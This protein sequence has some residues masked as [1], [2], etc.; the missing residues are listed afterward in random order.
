[1]I[2]PS[3]WSYAN[4]TRER[5]E[6]GSYGLVNLN[7]GY[8]WKGAKYR[9]TVGLNLRNALDR[10]MVA[11]IARAGQERQLGVSYLMIF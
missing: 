6:F 1:M 5:V 10:D 11:A 8:S 4:T 7:L 2:G 9:Q 3:V